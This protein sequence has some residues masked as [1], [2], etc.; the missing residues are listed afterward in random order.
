[1]S[2]AFNVEIIKSFSRTTS[3]NRVSAVQMIASGSCGTECKANAYDAFTTCKELVGVDKGT[4]GI[5]KA[6]ADMPES[7]W[8]KFTLASNDTTEGVKQATALVRLAQAWTLCNEAGVGYYEGYSDAGHALHIHYKKQELAQR[9]VS[10]SQVV[11]HE[12]PEAITPEEPTTATT[13]TKEG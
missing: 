6:L 7:V 4:V 1:M 2:N 3:A 13:N 9:K 8:S 10:T 5:Y 11:A 12:E